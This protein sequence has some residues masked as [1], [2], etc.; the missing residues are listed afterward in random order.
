MPRWAPKESNHHLWAQ[1]A[2][3]EGPHRLPSSR[4]IWGCF[5][6][7]D[8]GAGVQDVIGL[9]L[10]IGRRSDLR[11]GG[12]H[13]APAQADLWLRPL[14]EPGRPEPS[15]RGVTEAAAAGA[16]PALRIRVPKANVPETDTVQTAVDSGSTEPLA[17]LPGSP[18][19]SPERPRSPCP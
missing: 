7:A 5:L 12:G 19:P 1:E 2:G 11:I 4:S 10:A 6:G 17:R 18:R 15:A 14:P 16:A 9:S 8:R 13:C 3:R